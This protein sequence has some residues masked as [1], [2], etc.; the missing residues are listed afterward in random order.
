MDYS[1]VFPA[2]HK[3]G[4]SYLLLVALTVRILVPEYFWE[5]FEKHEGKL[6]RYTKLSQEEFEKY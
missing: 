2:F 1:V 4:T 6:L 5:E 3:K